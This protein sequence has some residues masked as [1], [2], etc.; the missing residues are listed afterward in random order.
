MY[1]YLYS[2][3]YGCSYRCIC[4]TRTSRVEITSDRCLTG[5]DRIYEVAKRYKAEQYI[6]LQG[7]EPL[8]P[9]ETIK[10][11]IKEAQKDKK[12]VHTAVKK[13]SNKDDFFNK[14]IPKMV[15]SKS[16]K[17]LFSSRAPIP[18]NKNGKLV[19]SV[20]GPS[21]GYVLDKNPKEIRLSNI[22]FAV[23]EEVKT[24]NCKKNS[25]KGCNNRLTKCITHN[26][27]DQ[28]DQHINGFF[29]KVKLQDLTRTN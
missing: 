18:F 9:T 12:I 21:G 28:L 25:K 5:T 7:D 23:D 3:S 19:K 16:K 27:W 24:L 10:F 17:L 1:T 22:I 2:Y 13:I 4:I 8:F 6:N 29:E 11:F 14:S 20:R 26:L 15:F